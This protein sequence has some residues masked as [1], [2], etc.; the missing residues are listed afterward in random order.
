MI[1]IKKAMFDQLTTSICDVPL[2]RND[3]FRSLFISSIDPIVIP[4][5]V[6]AISRGKY[7]S[8]RSSQYMRICCI[9]PISH[10]SNLSKFTIEILPY[11]HRKNAYLSYPT[12]GKWILFSIFH[13]I[14]RVSPTST[15][16]F[17]GISINMLTL[18]TLL[19]NALPLLLS[20]MSKLS[21]VSKLS[22][23]PLYTTLLSRVYTSA[24]RWTVMVSRRRKS[25]VRVWSC[26]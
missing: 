12:R 1:I 22:I 13:W 9:G 21:I 15:E 20:D 23:Y 6:L 3:D 25:D 11:H 24:S 19:Y 2:S 10:S 26:L 7:D 18:L 17:F 14:R 5:R 4:R 16:R 8:N